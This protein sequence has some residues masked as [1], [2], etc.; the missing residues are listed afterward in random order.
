MSKIA[1]QTFRDQKMATAKLALK[2]KCISI[3]QIRG[4]STLFVYEDQKLE[5]IKHAYNLTDNKDDYY[6]L[7][8]AFTFNMTK[9]DFNEFLQSKK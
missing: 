1:S 3:N 4:I 7:H 6:T 8:D 5:F 2:N 9:N